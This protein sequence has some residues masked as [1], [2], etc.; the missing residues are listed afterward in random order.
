MRKS[1]EITIESEHPALGG[2]VGSSAIFWPIS[3]EDVLNPVLSGGGN[4]ELSSESP[5]GEEKETPDDETQDNN[6]KIAKL[7]GMSKFML[8]TIMNYRCTQE[9]THRLVREPGP[10][11]GGSLAA[12]VINYNATIF[13]GIGSNE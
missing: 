7:T 10:S 8:F 2:E 4:D 13:S 6:P 3:A 1:D 9:S 5:E 11:A 12:L